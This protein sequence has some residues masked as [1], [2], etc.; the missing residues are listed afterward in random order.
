M[1]HILITMRSSFRFRNR[2]KRDTIKYRHENNCSCHYL[3]WR[4]ELL[5]LNLTSYMNIPEECNYLLF[6]Y[7][8][9]YHQICLSKLWKKYSYF[10]FK[11]IKCR[12]MFLKITVCSEIHIQEKVIKLNVL[13]CC[14]NNMCMFW[15]VILICIY[16][17]AD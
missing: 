1:L 5:F 13:W 14:G 17:A 9:C 15:N 3:A 4:T 7:L 16:I 12:E 11:K 2:G 6:R 10:Y 8:T